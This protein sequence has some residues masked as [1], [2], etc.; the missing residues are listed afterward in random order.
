MQ[1]P[2][3]TVHTRL[4]RR[5][6]RQYMHFHVYRKDLGWLKFTGGCLLVFLFGLINFRTDSPMLGWVFV[7]LA[8][9]LLVSRF[10][11]FYLSLDRICRQYGLDSLPRTFYTVTF[12]GS[13]LDVTSKTEHA[14]Y[15]WEQVYHAYRR[16]GILYLYMNPQTAYLLP[17]GMVEGG[18]LE[19]LW[20]LVCASLSPEKKTE[21]SH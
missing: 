17:D 4:T 2:A 20:A 15:S 6:Y 21:L 7:L 16:P 13:G 1:S 5:I 19:D 9:Y 14:S 11:R 8:A 18:T 3:I 10:L 12:T